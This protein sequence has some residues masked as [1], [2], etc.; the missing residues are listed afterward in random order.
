VR[1][2][3][4]S[5]SEVGGAGKSASILSQHLQKAG[6]DSRLLTRPALGLRKKLVSKGITFL[7]KLSSVSEYDF[8]SSHSM[9]T[10]DL[11]VLKVMQPQVIHIHNWYNLISVENFSRLARIAPLVFTLHD[12]R[13]V[14]GGCHVTL[15]CKKF[16]SACDGCP[17]HRLELSREQYRKE[18]ECFYESGQQYSVISPSVWMIEQLR[19]TALLSNAHSTA[20]IPNHLSSVNEILPPCQTSSDSIELIFVASNLDISYK[21]FEI[22]LS[23]MKILDSKIGELNK[24]ISLTLIGHTSKKKTIRLKNIKV[25][26]SEH[27]DS[28][29]LMNLMRRSDILVVPSLSENYPGVI[30]EAQTYGTRVVAHRVGGI[31]EMINDG[32]TGY[33]CSPDASSLAAKIFEA[34]LD[35][36][37]ER[38]RTNAFQEVLNRQDSS[39][40]IASHIDFY[41]KLL[42]VKS[43]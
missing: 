36:N 9:E 24:E 8:L 33:L 4:L 42:E 16:L 34:I 1:V 40:I 28:Q 21:G 29:A 19:N 12:E 3:H 35:T 38:V 43:A 30:A 27:L 10:L 6:I 20:V 13:L 15:G 14:T 7:G 5:T 39:K 22:L 25:L 37:S 32:V 41:T 2:L 31:P 18:L 11:N 23:A 17:A 26:H